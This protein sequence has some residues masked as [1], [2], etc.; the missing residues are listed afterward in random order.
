MLQ[1]W[2]SLKEDACEGAYESLCVRVRDAEREII[3]LK[4]Q[5]A[6]HRYKR[7]WAEAVLG[8]LVSWVSKLSGVLKGELP[9]LCPCALSFH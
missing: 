7:E 4:G 2:S 6:V 9:F 8:G 1:S 5:V 3:R